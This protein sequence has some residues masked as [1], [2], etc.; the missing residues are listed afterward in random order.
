MFVATSQSLGKGILDS[1]ATKTCVGKM[2]L[3]DHKQG[4]DKETLKGLVTRKENRSFRFG[5]SVRYPSEYEVDLPFKIGSIETV[6]RTSVINANIPLLIWLPD[7][8]KLKFVIDTDKLLLTVKRSGETFELEKT[9]KGH[10]S[11][12]FETPNVEEF[13]YS[14]EDEDHRGKLSKIKRIHHVMCH[15]SA[16]ILKNFFKDSSSNDKETMNIVD[17]VTNNCKICKIK[18][19]RSPPR[20]RVALPVSNNFNQCVSV[21]LRGPHNKKYILYCV[22]T[23]SRLT[24]G[25]IIKDKT[26]ST[27]VKG[28]LDCWVLGRGIGPGMPS[29][30]IH[31]NGREFNNP[32]MLDMCEKFGLTISNITAANSPFSNGIC[33]KNHQV[34]DKMMAK[35]KGAEPSMSDQE[36]LDHALHAKKWK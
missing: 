24:R 15:P 4:L 1:A 14:L 16:D 10:I 36:A 17:E 2:W 21:D 32:E 26:P 6:L 18:F 11:I 13:A 9:P 34:V 19:R 22:D 35:I 29:K 33:E 5:N 12:E 3:E 27:I 8:E 30:F 7:M 31:D 25:V 23:F 20:P 28:I